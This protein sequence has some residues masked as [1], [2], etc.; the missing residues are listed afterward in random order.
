MV[1][2]VKHYLKM[3]FSSLRV[4]IYSVL[5]LTFWKLTSKLQEKAFGA[6]SKFKTIKE[7]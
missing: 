3:Y 7:K 6:L 1:I 4:F 5:F 2:K